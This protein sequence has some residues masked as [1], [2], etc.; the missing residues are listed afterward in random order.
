MYNWR[1]RLEPSASMERSAERRTSPGLKINANY[2]SHFYITFRNDRRN[3]RSRHSEF[4]ICV[5]SLLV[6]AVEAVFC[7]R[8][9]AD[10]QNSVWMPAPWLNASFRFFVA[11]C[12]LWCYLP[13]I[14]DSSTFATKF[15]SDRFQSPICLHRYRGR[16][17]MK[18]QALKLTNHFPQEAE[19]L[20]LQM[21]APKQ[22]PEVELKFSALQVLV[23]RRGDEFS[24][25]LEAN[26]A[27]TN[28]KKYKK[29]WIKS[30][31]NGRVAAPTALLE[32]I[33]SLR[34]Q[35]V[36]CG[37]SLFLLLHFFINSFMFF[38]IKTIAILRYRAR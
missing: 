12:A 24:G 3:F 7:S 17:P 21:A 20:K 28:E 16:V 36:A 14:L 19:K 26:C 10:F 23:N 2:F 33:D 30:Q 15:S 27:W 9:S 35:Q 22:K 13:S 5:F 18:W 4:I 29:S 25:T 32:F 6:E 37:L 31:P 8:F 1:C 11:V 38:R 34:R